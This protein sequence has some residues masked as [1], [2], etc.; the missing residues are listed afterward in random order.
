MII[1][2]AN[3]LKEAD[4]GG[5]LTTDTQIASLSQKYRAIV[6]T[7][8]TDFVRFPSVQWYNPILGL[9]F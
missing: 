6:H 3:L 4:T 9:K 2:D 1:P 7:A 8:D 5:N